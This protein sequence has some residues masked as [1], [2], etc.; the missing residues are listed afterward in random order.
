M[1]NLRFFAFVLTSVPALV[2]GCDGDMTLGSGGT[3][4]SNGG[5]GGQGATA[6]GGAGSGASANG[7]S[8]NAGT[9]GAGTGGA[10]NASSGGSGGI[11]GECA[12]AACG[13]PCGSTLAS[14]VPHVCDGEGN[15][16][17]QNS[18]KCGTGGAG[19]GGALDCTDDPTVCGP[20]YGCICGGPG[21]GPH[22]C[23]CGL[24]CA[25][26]ANC[27]EAGQPVCCGADG[28]GI[29]TDACTCYCD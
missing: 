25:G 12:G 21:P 9:A 20:G 7:G 8:G 18:V 3:G 29:C 14:P 4:A 1:S 17:D 24:E 11:G 5:A 23:K 27:T 10:G 19:G 26:D 15:C 6:N 13:A 22:P 16:L 2:G 28:K